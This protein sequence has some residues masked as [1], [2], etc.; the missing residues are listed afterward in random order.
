[1]VSILAAT[2]VAHRAHCRYLAPELLAGKGVECGL[3]KADMFA[4][5]AMMYELA[6]GNP[7]PTGAQLSNTHACACV[8]IRGSQWVAVGWRR[9]EAA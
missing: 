8:T 3:D 4:L 2:N 6:T 7:L 9:W 5:G 1:M